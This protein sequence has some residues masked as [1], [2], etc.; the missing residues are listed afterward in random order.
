MNKGY[1]LKDEMRDQLIDTLAE[2][3]YDQ[4]TY[5]NIK[6]MLV[7]GFCGFDNMSDE[8]L[9]RRCEDRETFLE[10]VEQP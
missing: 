2:V 1:K 5:S 3:R 6:D 10:R 8:E 7:R 4:L 9:I